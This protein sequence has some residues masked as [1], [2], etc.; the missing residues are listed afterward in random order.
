[1]L[2]K[3]IDLLRKNQLNEIQRKSFNWEQLSGYGLGVR[4]M[5]FPEECN[6]KS[7]IGEFGWGGAAGDSVYVDPSVRLG[8]FYAHHMLNPQED[9]S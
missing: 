5:S 6:A 1:M 7:N 4:T 8:V 3:S 2:P 9:Y